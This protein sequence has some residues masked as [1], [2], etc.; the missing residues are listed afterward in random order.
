MVQKIVKYC[1]PYIY[2]YNSSLPI[3][4]CKKADI[5]LQNYNYITHTRLCLHI[6]MYNHTY[7]LQMGMPTEFQMGAGFKNPVPNLLEPLAP[8][9]EQ[10]DKSYFKWG[11]FSFIS[12]S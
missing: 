12:K 2:S 10:R 5:Q 7:K 3:W 4:V 11:L 6:Y 1:L 8:Q 9:A